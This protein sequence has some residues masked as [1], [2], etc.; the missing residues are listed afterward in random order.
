MLDK[1][2]TKYVSIVNVVRS[3]KTVAGEFGAGIIPVDKS[4]FDTAKQP[5]KLFILK[6]VFL[7][8]PEGVAIFKNS[9]ATD[10]A[11]AFEHFKT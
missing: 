3:T 9:Q 10:I 7:G 11:K 2:L 4:T 1:H 8:F 6:M 5:K